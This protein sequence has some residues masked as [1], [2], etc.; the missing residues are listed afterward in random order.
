MQH[1]GKEFHFVHGDIRNL[2]TCVEAGRRVDFIMHNA[3][4]G[5]SPVP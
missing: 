3:A 2:S 5:A 4:L 1:A